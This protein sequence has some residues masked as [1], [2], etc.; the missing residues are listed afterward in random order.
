L[1]AGFALCLGAGLATGFFTGFG[2]T[3]LLGFVVAFALAEAFFVAGFAAAFALLAGFLAAARAGLARPLAD[4]LD[5]G[6]RVMKSEL[7]TQNSVPG[8]PVEN[9]THYPRQLT[10]QPKSRDKEMFL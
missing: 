2:A 9:A 6:L 4:A 10:E 8:E 1:A 5:T 7:P 3:F